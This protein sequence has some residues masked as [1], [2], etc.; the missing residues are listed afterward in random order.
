MDA[1]SILTALVLVTEG[2]LFRLLDW[3]EAQRR[4]NRKEAAW[5]RVVGRKM[6]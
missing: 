1:I 4:R 3:A 2:F 5:M 6:S